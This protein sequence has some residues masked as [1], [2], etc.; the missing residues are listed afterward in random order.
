MDW[1]GIGERAA[2]SLVLGVL[3]A[4]LIWTLPQLP[5]PI[6]FGVLISLAIFI[7]DTLSNR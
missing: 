6:A 2:A 5:V 7:G 1:Q 3:A 4:F